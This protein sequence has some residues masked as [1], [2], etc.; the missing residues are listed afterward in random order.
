MPSG[1]WFTTIPPN[2]RGI[3]D[4]AG[5]SKWEECYGVLSSIHER[6]IGDGTGNP[7]FDILLETGEFYVEVSALDDKMGFT[8][9]TSYFLLKNGGS[10]D[11]LELL[12]AEPPQDRAVLGIPSA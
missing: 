3:V 9:C 1:V 7:E 10:A 4:V 8:Y 2:E 6:W 12:P 5:F 11:T